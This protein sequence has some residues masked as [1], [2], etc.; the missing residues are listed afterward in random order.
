MRPKVSEVLDRVIDELE[1]YDLG[2]NQL[3]DPAYLLDSEL[4]TSLGDLYQM[5]DGARLFNEELVLHRSTD[6]L[7]RDEF[8]VVGE[9]AGADLL[10][11]ADGHVVSVEPDTGEQI[12]EGT[13]IDRW[14][15]GFVDAAA[16]IY[17]RDGEFREDVFTEEGELS[18]EVE[19][20]R[21]RCFLKRDPKAPG[22]RWR[23]ARGLAEL[24]S[25]VEARN[26]LEKVVALAPMFGWAWFDLAKIS[27]GGSEFEGAYEE[28]EE[29]A[30]AAKGADH[31]GY[32]LAHL[33]RIASAAN[34][35]A[36]RAVA[37]S[38][39]VAADPDLL[40]NLLAGADAALGASGDARPL[41]D[42][43]AAIAPQNLRVIDL[44][45]RLP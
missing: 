40:E 10:V 45:R 3:N 15:G 36:E 35:E 23:L 25:M 42:L 38:A 14:L 12:V 31:E 1:R 16:L 13:A 17:E 34:R 28:M 33:A 6:I 8:L 26:H 24:G 27:E 43:A 9:A 29:A 5:F 39:A 37:A 30:S 11:A 41:F 19:L 22:P 32:F 7:R 44:G 18:K 21:Q 20:Q 4:P 2:V